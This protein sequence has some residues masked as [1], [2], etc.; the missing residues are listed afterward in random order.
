METWQQLSSFPPPSL[1]EAKMQ[2]PY[3]IIIEQHNGDNW[4]IEFES[5]EKK[6][7]ISKTK[8]KKNAGCSVETIF[9]PDYDGTRQQLDNAVAV[10]NDLETVDVDQLTSKSIMRMKQGET[11]K[12][13]KDIVSIFMEPEEA[14]Y[15][16]WV[17]AITKRIEMIIF[18]T[19][20]LDRIT[21][22]EE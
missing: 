22:K 2:K 15:D 1:K 6:D 10:F 5:C 16:V 13:A 7:V 20:N 21:E 19:V 12:A 11:K 3:W 9:I 17:D 14:K 8:E 18:E 4:E